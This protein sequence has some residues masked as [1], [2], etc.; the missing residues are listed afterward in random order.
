EG[1]LRSKARLF[2]SAIDNVTRRRVYQV[3]EV[4]NQSKAKELEGIFYP[5]SAAVVGVSANEQKMGTQWFRGLLSSGFKGPIY[6]VSQ[7]GGKVYGHEIYNNLTA[8]PG[9]V[10]LV[11][12]CIPRDFVL[13]LLDDCAAKKVRAVQF[14][15]AGFRE[16]GE[17]KW[18]EVEKEMVRRA[19]RGGFRII[20][21]NCFGIYCPEHGLP[22]GPWMPPGRGGSIAFIS[23]SG[24]HAGKLL[25]TGLTRGIEFGKAVSMGN[26]SDLGSADFLEYFALDPGTDAIGLYLEGPTDSRQLLQKM[27]AASERKPIVVWKGG[28]T[29]AGYRATASHTGALAASASVWSGALRQAGAIE[30]EGLEELADTLLLLQRVGPLHRSNLG[31]V[32]GLT[33]GGGGEAVLIGDACA[34]PGIVVPPL[35]E[36]TNKE[37]LAL[38][39]QVGSVL[40]NPID[41]SQRGGN[42]GTL[43]RTMHL[44]FT[45]TL[46]Y[47]Q[48]FWEHRSPMK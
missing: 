1:L 22:Y 28:R 25:H 5:R 39:G 16:T 4:L 35:T 36:K 2:S 33:D 23:Q 26:G 15:T 44:R 48:R 11:V 6:G 38:L 9:P 17:P 27:Q 14:F 30:T 37:L 41:I 13:D 21:P 45:R 8:I 7:S 34:A 40:S 29:A 42:K 19:R 46:T 10:D 31:I 12:V 24:G 20:G 3:T 18:A 43:E 32:C 47:C